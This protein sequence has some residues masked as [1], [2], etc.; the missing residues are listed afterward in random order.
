MP[1]S[2]TDARLSEEE[3]RM[4]WD[5][6]ENDS[7]VVI[8]RAGI[9]QGQGQSLQGAPRHRRSLLN[10]VGDIGKKLFFYQ[11]PLFQTRFIFP[12]IVLK[13]TMFIWRQMKSTLRTHVLRR[14]WNGECRDKKIL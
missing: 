3:I 9:R 12:D 14:V 8:E 2:S 4:R 5:I 10:Y 13:N 7:Y 6:S 11:L 1:P